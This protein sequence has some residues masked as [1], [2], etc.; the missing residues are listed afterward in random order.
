MVLLEII[1]ERRNQTS[2][3][4]EGEKARKVVKIGRFKSKNLFSIFFTTSGVVHISYLDK[5]KNIDY[6]TYIKDCLKPL[7]STLKQQYMVPKT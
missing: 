1:L 6:Q 3:V 4:A 7:A 2:W 5:E